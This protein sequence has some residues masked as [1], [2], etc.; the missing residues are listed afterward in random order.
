MKARQLHPWDVA[1]AEARRMQTELRK[2]L[3]L[4][5][6]LSELRCIAGA[7]VAIDDRGV[8]VA[9]VIVYRFPEMQELERASATLRVSFP[10]VPGLLS[11]RETPGLLK[12]FAR[13]RAAPDL[14]FCDAQGY[15]HPRRFGLACHLG[16]L[17]DR[18]TVGCA[19]S[20]L[21]G[22]HREPGTRRGAWTPLEDAGE[23]IGA[24]LRTR[25]GVRPIYVSQGYRVSLARAIELTLAVCDGYRIPRP[26]READH[27]VRALRT[28]G[29]RE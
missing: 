7:D 29:G 13:L 17:L 11:F 1:P 22:T 27:Y 10:Y 23:V 8:V 12:A 9:G 28:A 19:K 18:P 20:R 5:D 6:R 26:T 25:P 14:I 15:A 21:I 3:V 2:Q 4:D 16:L 24:V